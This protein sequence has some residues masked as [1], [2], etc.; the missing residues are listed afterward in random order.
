MRRWRKGRSGWRVPSDLGK[1]INAD[2]SLVHVVKAVIHEPRNQSR[3]TDCSHISKT[4]IGAPTA[5]TK[6][7]TLFAQKHQPIFYC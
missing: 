6:L 5:E 4:A 7:T 3:F 2:G 1:E